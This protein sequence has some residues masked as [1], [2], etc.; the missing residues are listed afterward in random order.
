MVFKISSVLSMSRLRVG[1][2]EMSVRNIASSLLIFIPPA[3]R[4]TLLI[5]KKYTPFPRAEPSN[6]SRNAFEAMRKRWSTYLPKQRTE[7]QSYRI[8]G[9]SLENVGFALFGRDRF[10]GLRDGRYP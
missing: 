4:P 3:K 8:V 5:A 10:E 6:G 1:N 9:S 2:G 7:H